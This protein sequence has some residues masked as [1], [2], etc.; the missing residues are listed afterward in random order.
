MVKLTAEK[1]GCRS[2]KFLFVEKL[3]LFGILFFCVIF[4]AFELLARSFFI[5]TKRDI[6]L[7]RPSFYYETKTTLAKLRFKSH[8]FLPYAPRPDDSRTL[9]AYKPDIDKTLNYNIRNNSLG[10]RTPERPFEKGPNTK[11][12]ITLGGST[13]WDGPENDKTWPALLEK[14]LD[15]YYQ[16]SD[17]KIEVINLA[18]DGAPSVMSLTVLNLIGVSYKPDL[19]ISHDGVNDFSIS[20]WQKVMPDYSNRIKPFNENIFLLPTFIP[21]FAY[22]SYLIS[23]VVSQLGPVLGHSV[24]I[25]SYIN[26]YDDG[27]GTDTNTVENGLL[28]YLRN[29]K[30]MRATCVEYDCKFVA[31]IPHWVNTSNELLNFDKQVRDFFGSEEINYLDLQNELPHGDFSIHS[32]K[33]HWTEKGLG[34]MADIWFKKIISEKLLGI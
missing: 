2:R 27:R 29:L 3:C 34:L 18:I 10:F 22:K 12:I 32:D 28:L 7:F 11:R 25:F 24:D 16:N 8:P 13:T 31:S 17:Y 15:D 23:V 20:S 19:V 4:L 1:M 26:Q 30:L 6:K 14:K 5:V 33:V 9:T 21:T